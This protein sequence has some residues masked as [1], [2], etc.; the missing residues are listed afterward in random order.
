MGGA[1]AII[2]ALILAGIGLTYLFDRHVM[3]SLASDLEV[4]LRKL[5]A[6]VELNSTGQPQ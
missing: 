1:A 3:R 6:T 2:A 4:H 5:V